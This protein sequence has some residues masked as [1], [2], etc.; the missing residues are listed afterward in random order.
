VINVGKSGVNLKD[1]NTIDANA[2]VL[3]S[4]VEQG[5]L[6]VL[7]VDPVNLTMD[8]IIKKHLFNS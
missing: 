2:A 4:A 5:P 3:S 1:A 7:R 8:V 6:V